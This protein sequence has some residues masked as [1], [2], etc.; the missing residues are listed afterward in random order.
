[1]VKVLKSGF[2]STIQDLGRIGY[3]HFGVPYSGVMDGYSASMANAILG[4]DKNAAAIEMTM[5]G[6]TLQFNC[7]TNICISGADMSPQINS[8]KIELNKIISVKVGDVLSFGRLNY[9]FRSYLAVSDGFKTK[10]VMNSRSMY[11]NITNQV[12]LYKNDELPISNSVVNSIKHASIKVNTN[13]FTSKIIEVFKGPEFDFLAVEQQEQ[14]FS[15]LFKI[16][17]ENNRMAYQLEDILANSL[18]PIITSSVLPGTVQLTP[19]GKLIILM[20]DCQTT[21]GYPRILQL[22]D[23]S[24][25]VLAQ[26][27]NGQNINFKLVKH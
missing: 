16:S 6:A 11:K 4:N 3:Q 25:D 22:K 26:K 17:K 23:T 14:L 13:H 9:G 1:M 10:V 24:I 12:I 8:N 15:K 5:T 7:N 18:K 21:G 20:R 27:F 19:F 2:Y